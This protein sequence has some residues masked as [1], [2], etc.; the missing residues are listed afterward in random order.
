MK[1]LIK[2]QANFIRAFFRFLKSF[3]LQ[4]FWVI[5]SILEGELRPLCSM[6]NDE[7]ETASPPP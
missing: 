2:T 4:A 5:M 1:I 3:L 7:E 6:Q